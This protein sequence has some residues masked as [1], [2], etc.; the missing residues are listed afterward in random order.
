MPE[1]STPLFF[2]SSKVAITFPTDGQI[3]LGVS[4]VLSLFDELLVRVGEVAGVVVGVP[5]GAAIGAGVVGVGVVASD[6]GGC[7]PLDVP[8]LVI[9]PVLVVGLF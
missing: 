9:V 3:K 7:G 4:P 1:I 2:D 5:E 6:E 8:T